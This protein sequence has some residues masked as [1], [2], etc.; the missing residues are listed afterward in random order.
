MKI[1]MRISVWCFFLVGAAV[2]WAPNARG[3]EDCT[4]T[5]LPLMARIAL[6]GRFPDYKIVTLADLES[7]DADY[8]RA[9]HPRDCP[10]V[11]AG[12]FGPRY[13]GYVVSLMRRLSADRL[14]AVLILLAHREK[15]FAVV[16]L[17]PDSKPVAQVPVIMTA[18][19]G[20]YE[21]A[22][23]TERVRTDWPLIIYAVIGDGSLAYYWKAGRFKSFTVAE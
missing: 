12:K 11:V 17:E 22:E 18:P 5:A 1:L 10:G 3:A 7:V 14:G 19:A 16:V 4:E 6:H 23:R 21:D 15:G 13:E 8:W 2:C 20:S 9:N